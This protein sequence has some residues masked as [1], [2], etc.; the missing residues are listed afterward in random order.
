MQ[1]VG[2]TCATEEGRTQPRSYELFAPDKVEYLRERL[3]I[4]VRCCKARMVTLD[5]KTRSFMKYTPYY[6]RAIQ[7]G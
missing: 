1:V 2:A 5:S 6:C 7:M 4:S 3:K